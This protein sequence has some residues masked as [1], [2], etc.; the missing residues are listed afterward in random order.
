MT[1]A[2]VEQ[3]IVPAAG[4]GTRMRPLTLAIPKEMLPL[5]RRPV[6]DYVVAEL[7]DAGIRR[8]LVVVSPG[9]EIIRT[10]LGDGTAHG[11]ACEYATQPEMRGLGDAILQGEEWAQSS[12][13][14]VA[15]GDCIIRSARHAGELPLS[16]ML[17]THVSNG[18]DATVLTEHVEPE[19]TR[20]YGILK[21]SSIID[22]PATAPFQV[23]ALVEKPQP[24]QAPSR[25]AVAARWVLEPAVFARLRS[26]APG[27]NGEIGLTE[28]VGA[29]AKEGARVW[30][31]PLL[32][33]EARCD[34]G[35]WKTYLAAAAQAACQDEEC[36]EAVR[37][38]LALP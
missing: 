35:G 33:G 25:Q 23:A 27:P 32:P 36:G 8:I 1:P 30:A 11:V 34:I 19:A 15:F 10:Y 18:A 9:K 38:T 16:R 20:R 22:E 5:G 17:R 31:E 12:P 13:F 3:A 21:P 4:Y 7:R 28:H 26:A 24:D 6:L 2:A 29:W 14:V 37:A